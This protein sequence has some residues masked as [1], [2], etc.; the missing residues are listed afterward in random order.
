MQREGE[1]VLGGHPPLFSREGE[2]GGEL[3]VFSDTNSIWQKISKQSFFLLV[4]SL[5]RIGVSKIYELI[6]LNHGS[7]INPM[8]PG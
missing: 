2:R 4:F 1:N 3:S 5:L 7:P 8:N 6:G